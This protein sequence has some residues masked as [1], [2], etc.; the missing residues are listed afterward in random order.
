MGEIE[1]GH[2]KSAGIISVIILCFALVD[3]IVG[4]VWVSYGGRDASG[5][6]LGLLVS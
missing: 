2:G 1:A 6:W 4:F 5:L 3:V